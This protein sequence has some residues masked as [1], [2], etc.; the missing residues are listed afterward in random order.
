MSRATAP[1]RAEFPVFKTLTTRWFDNDLYG[2]MNN[3]VHYQL[4]D[5]VVNGHLLEE[6]LLELHNSETAFLVVES[7]CSYFSEIGFPD[8]ITAGLRVAKL[9]SSSVTYN[10]ALFRGDSDVAAAAGH[11]IHVHVDRATRKPRPMDARARQVLGELVC[12]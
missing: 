11:F 8:V 6:G 3:A 10:V 4:F 5:T 1:T 7:G 12:A 2:H 9:G